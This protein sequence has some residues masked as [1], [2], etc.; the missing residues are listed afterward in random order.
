MD[1][2]YLL[3]YGKCVCINSRIKGFI[4]LKPKPVFFNLFN[5]PY[6]FI[7]QDNQTYHQCTQ[8][9]AFIKNTKVTNSYS[10]E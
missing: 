4:K 8:W 1:L 7:R 10:L 6:P 9:C 5:I 3:E 2:Y